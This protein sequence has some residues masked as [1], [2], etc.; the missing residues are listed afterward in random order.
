M[1]FFSKTIKGLEYSFA[2]DPDS[3]DRVLVRVDNTDLK[4]SILS[5]DKVSIKG[6]KNLNI[7]AEVLFVPDEVK[8]KYH[9]KALKKRLDR[10]IIT[11]VNDTI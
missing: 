10:I 9:D 5:I 6:E 4:G 2:E 7:N 3:D 11:V 1:G 8:N